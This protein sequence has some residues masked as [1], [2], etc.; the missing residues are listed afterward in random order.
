[1]RSVARSA[2]PRLSRTMVAAARGMDT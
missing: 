2:E 1:L